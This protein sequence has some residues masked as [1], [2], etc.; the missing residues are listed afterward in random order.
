MA[1]NLRGLD[2]LLGTS[3]T[4]SGTLRRQGKTG[5]VPSLACLSSPGELVALHVTRR[6]TNLS[7]FYFSG[8][9]WSRAW[10]RW[11][12]GGTCSFPYRSSLHLFCSLL[13][14]VPIC[15]YCRRLGRPGAATIVL[16]VWWHHVRF[17]CGR[18]VASIPSVSRRQ[19]L[20]ESA[21]KCVRRLSGIVGFLDHS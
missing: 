21:C 12:C 17:A 11:V 4:S 19:D 8:S 16:L 5:C 15:C 3:R 20:T 6:S 18:A 7:L 10:L 1:A 14:I 2:V 9:L 13:S